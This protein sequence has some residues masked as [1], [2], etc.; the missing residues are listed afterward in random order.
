[1]PESSTSNSGDPPSQTLYNEVN[2]KLHEP[3]DSPTDL[4]ASFVSSHSKRKKIIQ[5]LNCT[6]EKKETIPK[7]KQIIVWR[8]KK[9]ISQYLLYRSR[10]TWT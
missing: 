5:L 1:M 9:K 10:V 3:N 4:S 8:D 2:E 7:K 6:N